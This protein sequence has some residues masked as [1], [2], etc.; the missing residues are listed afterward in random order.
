MRHRGSSGPMCGPSG[1]KQGRRRSCA[2][3][4]DHP[5]QS[6]G[7][8]APPQRAPP[9]GTPL[10]ICAAQIGDNTVVQSFSSCFSPN[11]LNTLSLPISSHLI[12][13]TP[14]HHHEGFLLL[15]LHRLI[16]QGLPSLDYSALIE[17][18]LLPSCCCPPPLIQ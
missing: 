14:Q 7:P 11:K 3:V 13:P 4:A 15:V 8:S 5:A 16:Q 1:A 9:G 2:Q 12:N 10:V 17:D 18:I 6:R